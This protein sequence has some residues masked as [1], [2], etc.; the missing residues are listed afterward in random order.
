MAPMGTMIFSGGVERLKDC[1]YV[2]S[3]GFPLGYLL[4]DSRDRGYKQTF[5]DSGGVAAVLGWLLDNCGSAAMD[6]TLTTNS[7]PIWGEPFPI[8]DL[9]TKLLYRYRPGQAE[10]IIHANSSYVG[11]C[12]QSV[13]IFQ[14]LQAAIE[15][16]GAENFDGQAFYNAATRYRTSGPMWE[17]YPGWAFGETKR[18]L[19]DHC[20]IYEFDTAA[21]KLVRLSDW[22]PSTG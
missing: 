16:V 8:V 3:S 17:G 1:D 15:E 13:A 21:Q 7:S 22:L 6:G 5:M 20:L 2:V 4:K 19:V 18:H 10:E 9:A 12:H 14:V 11:G